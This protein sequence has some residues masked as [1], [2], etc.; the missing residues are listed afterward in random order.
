MIN[1]CSRFS[2]GL[3]TGKIDLRGQTSYIYK[4]NLEIFNIS[5]HLD[6]KRRKSFLKEIL[7]RKYS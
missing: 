1:I 6:I 4:T 2:F 3:R 5:L 7:K